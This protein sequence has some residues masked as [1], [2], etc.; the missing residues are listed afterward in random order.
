MRLVHSPSELWID[1]DRVGLLEAMR[2]V[3]QNAVDACRENDSI[4]WTIEDDGSEIRLS[5]ED[6]GPGLSLTARARAFDLFYSGREA[7][8]G[9]GVSLA[10]VHRLVSESGGSI[11]LSSQ[12]RIGC[13]VEIR[14]SKTDT[15]GENP[16]PLGRT[17]P[18]KI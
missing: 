1:A 12:S 8:R 10:V 18:W 4:L 2:L 5:I 14:F 13:R 3:C 16:G 17:G 15:C 11:S 7:G 6:T 9:L